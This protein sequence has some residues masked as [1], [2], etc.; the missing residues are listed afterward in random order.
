[1]IC[2]RLVLVAAAALAALS[3]AACGGSSA[4]AVPTYCP[5]PFT[6]TDAGRL[7]H[8]KDGPG[9]DPRDIA[10]EAVVAGSRTTCEVSR[11]QI[12]VTLLMR[13]SVNAGPA[14]GSG[15]TRV[16]YFVRVIDG[17][18][19]VVQGQEFTADFRLSAA[20][21]KGSSQEELSL[22]LPQGGSYRIAIGLKPTAEELNY[23]RRGRQ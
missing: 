20:N 16:P 18:G 14:V 13:I 9:R 2:R 23:N 6:V 8:F 17:S 5:S 1:M 15:P 22:F 3:L 7:T 21:P 4:D 19:A 12:N 11:N 10:Y